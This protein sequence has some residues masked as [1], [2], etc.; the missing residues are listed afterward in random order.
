MLASD[1]A[2]LPQA[3]MGWS[4]KCFNFQ[5]NT[6]TG[7]P[8]GLLNEFSPLYDYA[9]SAQA[10]RVNGTL[11]GAATVYWQPWSYSDGQPVWTFNYSS[12]VPLPDT[13]LKANIAVSSIRDEVRYIEPGFMLGR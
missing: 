1:V 11:A 8:T 2:R 9:K 4:G 5:F 13:V 12:A 3:N 10:Q 7:T 6:T